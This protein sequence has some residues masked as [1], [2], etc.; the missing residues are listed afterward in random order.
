MMGDGRLEGPHTKILLIQVQSFLQE[1]QWQFI[2]SYCVEDEPGI[3]VQKCNM[4]MVFPTDEDTQVASSGREMWCDVKIKQRR[5]WRYLDGLVPL[6]E[7]SPV[8][9]FEGSGYLI[10]CKAV[11]GEVRVLKDRHGM[12]NS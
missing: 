3:A 8:E 4:R 7:D 1:F 10:I 11:E 6:N 2:L 5:K 12:V 9:E